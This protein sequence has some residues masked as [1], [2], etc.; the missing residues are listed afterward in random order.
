MICE[1]RRTLLYKILVDLCYENNTINKALCEKV[2]DE[3]AM[4]SKR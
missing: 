2:A 3:T 4:K 1:I